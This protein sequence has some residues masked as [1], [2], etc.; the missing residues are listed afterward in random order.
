MTPGFRQR[1]LTAFSGCEFIRRR[2]AYFTLAAITHKFSEER[3]WPNLRRQVL[4]F[5]AANLFAEE[6][7]LG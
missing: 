1:R 6:S 3:Q 7:L 2:V 4:L 5:F